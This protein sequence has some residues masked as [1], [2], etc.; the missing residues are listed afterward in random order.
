MGLAAHQYQDKQ[1]PQLTP[2]EGYEGKAD[3]PP[4]I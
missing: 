3:L 2:V 1:R 4:C